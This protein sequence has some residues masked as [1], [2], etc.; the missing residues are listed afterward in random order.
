MYPSQPKRN[1]VYLI[2]SQENGSGLSSN[3]SSGS[4]KRENPHKYLLYK[5]SVWQF[6]VFLASGHRELPANGAILLY[7]SGDGCYSTNP[8]PEDPGSVP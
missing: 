4:S 1:V 5:P 7:L 6:L 2:F 8:N 3:A